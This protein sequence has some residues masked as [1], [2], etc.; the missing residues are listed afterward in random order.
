[1]DTRTICDF[2]GEYDF[3]SN[4]YPWG[5][6]TLEHRFQAAKTTNE[7]QVAWIMAAPT[8]SEAK[9]RGR[10]VQLRDDWD[11]Y[12]RYTI[13][14]QLLAAKFAT[15]SEMADR[16]VATDPAILIEGNRWHD[17]LWGDCRCGRKPCAAT[18]ANLL[19]WMLMQRRCE[20]RMSRG[21]IGTP[22]WE[23]SK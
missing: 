11:T 19:G 7:Q 22:Y 20:L 18:G 13:M 17:Q 15:G 16:L 23:G 5:T 2:R 8:A 14:E 3:L 9:R 1:M 21:L 4:F 12:W 6:V 10:A